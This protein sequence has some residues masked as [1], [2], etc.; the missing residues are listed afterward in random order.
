[1]F[2]LLLGI[3]FGDQGAAQPIAGIH[4]PEETLAL[5]NTQVDLV[6]F[7]QTRRETFSVPEIG[8]HAKS[9]R[10]LPHPSAHFLQL[11]GGE[12]GRS[13]G[14]VS[15]RQTGQPVELKMLHPIGERARGVSKEPGGLL[16]TH[17]R[18]NKQHAVE[19]VIVSGILMAID[20]LLEHSP[21]VLGCG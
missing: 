7:L 15:L 20:F 18:S 14:M 12:P 6:M 21:A 16:A 2:R 8:I 17:S 4:Q 10:R 5:T 1:M 11:L 19:P 3:G 9:S 13:P